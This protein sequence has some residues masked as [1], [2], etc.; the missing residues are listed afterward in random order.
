ML[1][2]FNSLEHPFLSQSRNT[3]CRDRGSSRWTHVA[4]GGLSL[5]GELGEERES[6]EQEALWCFYHQNHG[7]LHTDGCHGLLRRGE[8]D[9]DGGDGNSYN[10][11]VLSVTSEGGSSECDDDSIR[12]QLLVTVTTVIERSLD[13]GDEMRLAC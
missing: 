10:E 8:D 3:V 9:G 5:C 11:C 6:T 4:W 2:S 13:G 1:G 7:S 12:H